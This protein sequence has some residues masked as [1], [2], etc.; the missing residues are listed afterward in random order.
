MIQE[1]EA[2]AG[3]R[4]VIPPHIVLLGGVIH[5]VCQSH[6]LGRRT[7][8]LVLI[9]GYI[10]AEAQCTQ[11]IPSD[12]LLGAT[13]LGHLDADVVALGAGFAQVAN[14]A[15]VELFRAAGRGRGAAIAPDSST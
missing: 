15:P 12:G 13:S 2:E 8:A 11:A 10:G 9:G 5:V 14:A 3:V 1:A 6:I 7:A 4:V